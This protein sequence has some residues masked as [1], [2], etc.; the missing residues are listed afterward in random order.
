MTTQQ[1]QAQQPQEEQ[2]EPIGE[3]LP[4]VEEV[5]KTKFNFAPWILVSGDQGIG[6]STFAASG[7]G[8]Y[9]LDTEGKAWMYPDGYLRRYEYNAGMF[10]KLVSDVKNLTKT[11]KRIPRGI[12]IN[13]KQIKYLVI[14]TF[15]AV[16]EHLLTHYL[17]QKEL[18]EWEKKKKAIN[19]NYIAAPRMEMQDWGTILRIQSPLITAL[20]QT[21]LPVV[22]VVHTTEER[23][24]QYKYEKLVTPGRVDMT[25]AGS[26][27]N[28]IMNNMS[29]GL[30]LHNV[31]GQVVAETAPGA[32]IEDYDI[33][34]IKD[35]GLW[36]R[37]PFVVKF[38]RS[39]MACTHRYI[40]LIL[41]KHNYE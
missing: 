6:K 41:E 18:P 17:E 28:K 3:A 5:A 26:I 33:K 34:T 2:Q 25:V 36:D 12:E 32:R 1:N 22:F 21:F 10:D 11:A 20:K 40:D 30:W 16:Q 31:S 35:T 7:T 13:N 15:D 14:D 37:K 29:Y 27:S 24:P 8:G 19:P 38:D 4:K 39:T 9:C 23:H